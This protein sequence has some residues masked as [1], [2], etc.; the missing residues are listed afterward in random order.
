MFPD[1]PQRFLIAMS[2]ILTF[3]VPGDYRYKMSLV[4]GEESTS[5]ERTIFVRQIRQFLLPVEFRVSQ[6]DLRFGSVVSFPR[7][8]I[9]L[10]PP[11]AKTFGATWQSL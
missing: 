8:I 11:G 10:T 4:A 9:T 6:L 1:L 3:E 5:G 2:A 7:H